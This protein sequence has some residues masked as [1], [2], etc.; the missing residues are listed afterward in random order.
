M[1]TQSYWNAGENIGRVKVT[2][3][4]GFVHGRNDSPFMRTKNIVTFSFQHAPQGTHTIQL[5]DTDEG[6]ADTR[7]VCSRTLASLG[8]TR[9]CGYL[10][11]NLFTMLDL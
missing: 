11:H 5:S 8:Q 2:I 1:L 7:K 3:A 4:E 9:E 10:H 6:Q